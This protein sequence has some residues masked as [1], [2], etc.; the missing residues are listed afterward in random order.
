[1]ADICFYD[2]LVRG[3]ETITSY[4]S[5][6]NNRLFIAIPSHPDVSIEEIKIDNISVSEF[7]GKRGFIIN[8]NENVTF[9]MKSSKSKSILQVNAWL[10]PSTFCPTSA[11]YTYGSRTMKLEKSLSKPDFCIFPNSRFQE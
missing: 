2:I 3:G 5:N 7:S 11:I 6:G 1:M 10:I 9:K 8:G 4:L